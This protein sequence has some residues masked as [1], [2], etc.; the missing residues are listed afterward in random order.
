[1]RALYLAGVAACG[2]GLS[3]QS[4]VSAEIW[5]KLC[6]CLSLHMLMGSL[7]LGGV[8][9]YPFGTDVCEATSSNASKY[10]GHQMRRDP[11]LHRLS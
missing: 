5:G 9:L 11:S 2:R 8:L 1:L 3:D 7:D 10:Y 6:L 4:C